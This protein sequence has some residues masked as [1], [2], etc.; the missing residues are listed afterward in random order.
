MTEIEPVPEP[1][2]DIAATEIE[3]PDREVAADATADTTT[4]ELSAQDTPQDPD[5]VTASASAGASVAAE[6]AT[7]VAEAIGATAETTAV[8][9][10]M[11]P[12][13]AATGQAAEASA[14]E[15]T[16]D[17]TAIAA[18]LD[19][20]DAV[21]AASAAAQSAN[22]TALG[23]ALQISMI[24]RL[25]DTALDAGQPFAGE[26]A[27]LEAMAAQVQI[28]GG[29]LT[30]I[31]APLANHA[32]Q[33]LASNATLAAQ[34]GALAVALE[35]AGA[36]AGVPNGGQGFF[37]RVWARLAGI[38]SVS[39]VDDDAAGEG[40]QSE[41][42]SVMAL[43]GERLG[44]GDFH[45]AATLFAPLEAALT[46]QETPADIAAD[47]SA[48]LDQARARDAAIKVIVALRVHGLDRLATADG[49]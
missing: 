36:P 25:L 4:Q 33:G 8:E 45:G 24:T 6:P 43:I 32:G 35:D 39:R 3:T 38:V 1:E 16:A 44:G 7:E 13:E 28:G 22:L 29:D 48:W 34:L 20:L 41:L 31:I 42:Q 12:L 19:E 11:M 47:L 23:D 37:G 30:T 27:A 46:N 10:E 17:Q 18:R 49:P 15:L 2:P 9:A 14:D 21:L 5:S 40:D 26:Y